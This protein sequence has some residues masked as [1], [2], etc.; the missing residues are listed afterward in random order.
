[1]QQE[2]SALAALAGS[3]PP[4]MLCTTIACL[5][6][7]WSILFF[8]RS[9]EQLADACL[10]LSVA[11]RPLRW[12]GAVLPL[13]PRT[14]AG[15][16]SLQQLREST[17]PLL[18]GVLQPALAP[19]LA[20]PVP[21][22]RR[23]LH[24]LL[25]APDERASAAL[26][27][28]DGRDAASL[29]RLPS[30]EALALRSA[31]GRFGREASVGRSVTSRTAPSGAGGDG[32]GAPSAALGERVPPQS[33]P[34]GGLTVIEACGGD[35]RFEAPL[36]AECAAREADGTEA[37]TGKLKEALAQCAV[38]LEALASSS[39]RAG[40]P[41]EIDSQIALETMDE[42]EGREIEGIDETETMNSTERIDECELDVATG[43]SPASIGVG[44]A[45]SCSTN[46]GS[47]HAAPELVNDMLADGG[48]GACARGLATSM[49]FARTSLA[50]TE[51]RVAA[52]EEAAASAEAPA[53][54]AAA[55]PP[56]LRGPFSLPTADSLLKQS[57]TLGD[58][59][60]GA[61]DSL[62]AADRLT[63]SMASM[64][65]QLQY[66]MSASVREWCK[67]AAGEVHDLCWELSLVSD[68][69]LAQAARQLQLQ[70]NQLSL[71]HQR[72][73]PSALSEEVAGG[74]QE[75]LGA[76]SSPSP[77]AALSELEK[78]LD[79]T[80]STLSLAL[81]GCLEVTV[82]PPQ[83]TPL[84]PRSYPAPA[85]FLLRSWPPPAPL[86]PSSRPPPAL[87]PPSSRPP[88]TP[89]LL[90]PPAYPPQP[91][92]PL[93]IP[94]TPRTRKPALPR[95]RPRRLPTLTS[96]AFS[97]AHNS[98]LP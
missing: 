20:P 58:A 13:V 31:L 72:W 79:S 2:Q 64:Q 77:L 24:V 16:A 28:M 43:A 12:C 54:S 32:V 70:L 93:P 94:P 76:V 10:A 8:S 84:L 49:H 81:L 71:P 47:V 66:L 62:P 42:V 95:R 23:A 7:G 53:G 50:R 1:M 67:H 14:G 80:D 87:L 18:A 89:T 73:M 90:G 48:V 86:P 44:G 26:V 75:E 22:T 82:T 88:P 30:R 96:S 33:A 15:G 21:H 56:V 52:L 59:L 34:E 19:L 6:A 35:G 97:C 25:P 45:K 27:T 98:L 36:G 91:P 5:S 65:S 4:E 83:P 61:A 39:R 46:G 57:E 92:P 29:P 51:A 78:A 41:S 85:P 74:G 17:I 9:P 40:A 55:E 11:V 60:A 63:L 38:A 3:L 37:A 68:I 69:S